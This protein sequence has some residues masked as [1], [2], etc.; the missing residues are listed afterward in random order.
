MI[1]SA[2]SRR[3]PLQSSSKNLRAIA[4][5][6]VDTL[7][8]IYCGGLPGP[9]ALVRSGVRFGSGATPLGKSRSSWP[10]T[11][12]RRLATRKPRSRAPASADMGCLRPAEE[13]HQ[14][15]RLTAPR[16]RDL[17]GGGA[18]ERDVVPVRAHAGADA[19]GA[20]GALHAR[21]GTRARRCRSRAPAG[22]SRGRRRAWHRSGRR[23]RA[24]GA[25]SW[26]P[27]RTPRTGRRPEIT[28]LLL[29]P[30]PCACAAVR[31]TDHLHQV[32][33]RGARG[34][35]AP[36]D[37]ADG[38]VLVAGHALAGAVAE[39]GGRRLEGDVVAVVAHRGVAARTVA[40]TAAA[41]RSRAA[42]RRASPH[43]RGSAGA[44]G[45]RPGRRGRRRRPCRW[46]AGRAG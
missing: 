4:S 38:S 23:R 46:S 8:P 13:P 17:P 40:R 30:L 27:S 24:W 33:R 2:T 14:H 20:E 39:V 16:I 41:R 43:G 36:E 7:P 9:W 28:G 21:A 37:V 45:T 25:G 10:R 22:S 44:P 26:P 15:V 34:H 31:V 29:G 1:S 12:D 5:F 11:Q 42:P 19:R 3:R 35:R 32:V 18:G 6:S